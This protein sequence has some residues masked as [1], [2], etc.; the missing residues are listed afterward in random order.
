M[1]GISLTTLRNEVALTQGTEE[2]GA[3]ADET[4]SD[5]SKRIDVIL[6]HTKQGRKQVMTRASTFPGAILATVLLAASP[7]YAQWSST[8]SM[9]EARTAHTMT[10][11]SDG[12]ALVTGGCGGNGACLIR[13]SAEIYDPALGTFE[14][15]GSMTAFRQS[16]AA[17]LLDNGKVL[18]VGGFGQ[19]QTSE[20]YDPGNGTFGSVANLNEGRQ[21]HQLV[22]LVNGQVLV[23]GG[24]LCC[25]DTRSSAELFDPTLN[26]WSPTTGDMT[27]PRTNHAATLLSDGRVLITGGTSDAEAGVPVATAEIYDPSS[28]TFS[29]VANSMVLARQQHDATLL[30]DGRV[31]ITGGF[32]GDPPTETNTAEIYDPAA[33]TFTA[34]GS[35]FATRARHVERNAVLLPDGRVIV[36]GGAPATTSVD[37]FDP[38]SEMFTSTFAMQ[39][40]R[41]QHGAVFLPGTG[42]VLAAGGNDGIACCGQ[43]SAEVIGEFGL[44]T[45]QIA[46]PL[47]GTIPDSDESL[48]PYNAPINS[49]FDHSMANSLGRYQLYGDVFSLDPA[50]K[51][52]GIVTA[53]TNEVGNKRTNGSK[54]C[55]SQAGGHPFYVNGNFLGVP[56]DA[57]LCYDNHPGIDYDAQEGM[58]VYAAA[59]GVIDYPD[60]IVGLRSPSGR[61]F[62][63]FHVLRLI[64]NQS[65]D[66]ELYYLHLS[67]HPSC[68]M[69]QASIVAAVRGLTPQQKKKNNWLRDYAQCWSHEAEPVGN[70]GEGCPS[71]IPPPEGPVKK[72]C[73][74][75]RVGDAGA[76]GAFHLHFEVQK[77][78][79]SLSEINPAAAAVL[80]CIDDLDHA[81]IPVDPY[82]WDDNSIDDPYDALVGIDDLNVRLWDHRPIIHSVEAQIASQGEIDLHILGDGLGD[83]T[84]CLV[85]RTQYRQS[86]S[87]ECLEGGSILSQGPSQLSVRHALASGTYFVHVEN[88]IGR[89]SNWA[90]LV[91]P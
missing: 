72:G 13:N 20:V 85:D 27:I 44:P 18:V 91:V 49:V 90:E 34:V 67:T 89:R 61:A 59:D 17:I 15:T 12:R 75:G 83:A 65:D 69:P 24:F 73:L 16:H 14:F 40:G 77:T 81:C 1:P 38:S 8:D 71:S 37:L 52:D 9:G 68:L 82:G 6:Q 39:N 63:G 78:S 42:Q 56:S 11:L 47:R 53:Y 36:V 32:T 51:T 57:H 64:P 3:S 55:Y 19:S 26:A 23:T 46:F 43:T 79:V 28:G 7:S 74:V 21:Q 84:D 25:Y 35:M 87:T 30:A 4:S 50:T 5:P 60:N 80:A 10:V 62:F 22:L 76:P 66:Y 2:L 29:P 88:P 54:D 86:G 45:L 58:Q 48:H 31:L 33:G 41:F 70:P